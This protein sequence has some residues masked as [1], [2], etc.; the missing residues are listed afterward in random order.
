MR[1]YHLLPVFL[2]SASLT[3]KGMF[4]TGLAYTFT[5]NHKKARVAKLNALLKS[6]AVAANLSVSYPVP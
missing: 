3:H 2:S 4:G 6:K 1:E 5:L